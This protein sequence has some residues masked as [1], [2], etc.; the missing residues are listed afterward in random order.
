[1]V[2]RSAARV[3]R[4]DEKP[5]GDRWPAPVRQVA[6]DSW[7]TAF[8]RDDDEAA[9]GSYVYAPGGGLEEGRENNNN[10]NQQQ[11]RS[12]APGR[13][14]HNYFIVFTCGRRTRYVAARILSRRNNRLLVDETRYGTTVLDFSPAS[15]G[16]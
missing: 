14:Y 9:E 12:P 15:D 16:A 4:A 13:A 5:A 10:K 7:N 3:I 2:S 8:K 6:P 11:P 1:M